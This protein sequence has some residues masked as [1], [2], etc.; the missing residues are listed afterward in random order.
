[1]T[2]INPLATVTDAFIEYRPS[3]HFLNDAPEVVRLAVNVLVCESS[4]GLWI[5][6]PGPGDP[7]AWIDD[8][9][10]EARRMRF[11]VHGQLLNYLQPL[12]GPNAVTN[13][14]LTHHHCDHCGA[15][16]T[17]R[18]A[19]ERVFVNARIWSPDVVELGRLSAA[20]LGQEDVYPIGNPHSPAAPFDAYSC[21][22]H[23]PHHTT[24][25]LEYGTTKLVV[26]GDIIP[27]AMHLRP[28]FRR[29]LFDEQPPDFYSRLLA[30]SVQ[31]R[32]VNFFSHDT[33][34]ATVR[35]VR[36]NDTYRVCEEGILPHKFGGWPTAA[37]RERNI[38]KT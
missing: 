32:Y 15:L 37:P 36:H 22:C 23:M 33:R 11:I 21:D 1:M 35:L 2:R 30:Q 7:G 8:I 29:L 31:D 12:G 24:Y 5:F 25:V 14:V 6:D 34:R 20:Y 16:F 3:A 18:G 4:E 28:R 9:D 19:R 10:D 13:I 27:T 17:V 38:P 26:W